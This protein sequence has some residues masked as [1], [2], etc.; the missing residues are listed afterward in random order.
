MKI[1]P[2]MLRSYVSRIENIE[3]EIKT[4]NEDKRDIYAEAKSRGFDVPALKAVIAYRRK[5]QSDAK[6]HD[7]L[8][9]TYLDVVQGNSDAGMEDA[10]RARATSV[11]A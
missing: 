3:K 5:D 9:R 2:E 7:T 11:A 1:A 8:F 6:E 4:H 10:T